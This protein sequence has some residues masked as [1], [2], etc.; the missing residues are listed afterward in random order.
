MSDYIQSKEHIQLAY[1]MAVQSIV[2]LKN[3]PD[4]G[5]PITSPYN[6]ACVSLIFRFVKNFSLIILRPYYSFTKLFK[7]QQ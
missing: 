1:D 5:L 2:L 6:K 7:V 4:N 3:A